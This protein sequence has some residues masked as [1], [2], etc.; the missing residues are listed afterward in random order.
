MIVKK[1]YICK[2]DD[3]NLTN[4]VNHEMDQ[5]HGL[6]NDLYESLMDQENEIVVS[7]IEEMIKLLKNI[8]KSHK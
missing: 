1:G 2:M 4:Y 7:T 5:L 8:Q 6:S 3:N